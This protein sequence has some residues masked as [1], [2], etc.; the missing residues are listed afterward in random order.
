MSK[1]MLKEFFSQREDLN[2]EPRHDFEKE[3]IES[4]NRRI[5]QLETRRRWYSVLMIISFIV[6]ACVAISRYVSLDT[7]TGIGGFSYELN[8]SNLIMAS[9]LFTIIFISSYQISTLEIRSL[10]RQIEEMKNK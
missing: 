5:E 8:A 7:L 3:L 9:L 10:K 2:T 6:M 4:L 1:D